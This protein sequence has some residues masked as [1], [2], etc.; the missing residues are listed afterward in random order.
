MTSWRKIR[1]SNRYEVSDD[2]DVRGP[3]GRILK[4]TLMQIGYYSIAISL[5]N[6]KVVRRYVHRLVADAFLGSTPKG[7]VV[8][9]KNHDKLDN[10]LTNLEVVTRGSNAEHWAGPNRSSSAGRQRTGYCDRGHNLSPARIYCL[11]CRR[12]KASGHDYLPPSDTEWRK[13][14]VAGYL[15]SRDGR[16]W[17]ENV[18]RLLK[19]GLNKPGYHYFNL[20]Q[21]GNTKPFAL[22]R[23]VAEAFVRPIEPSE[24]VDHINGD[25]LDNR[26][27]NLRITTR[28]KNTVSFR[29]RVRHQGKHG[30]KLTEKDVI[31]IKHLLCSEEITQKGIGER[32]SV[33]QSI[34]SAI[35]LGQKWKHV[36]ASGD[37][38]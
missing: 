31:E 24:V 7:C 35:K 5:G 10:R 14:V 27:E 22:H 17:S 1:E 32:F 19:P 2:G 6:H 28:S 8:N 12:Q 36:P 20:R 38:N 33:G 18:R 4:P 9:H 37:V 13:S 21:D 29:N 11:E 25:Q 30:Y 26:L 23:L 3:S 16:L 34:I 15:V